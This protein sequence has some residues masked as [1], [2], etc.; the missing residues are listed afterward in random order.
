MTTIEQRVIDALQPGGSDLTIQHGGPDNLDWTWRASCNDGATGTYREGVGQ[1][2]Q[3]ALDA[4][5]AKLAESDGPKCCMC[6]RYRTVQDAYDYNPLQVV[7]G[8]PLG[9]YSGDDGEICPQC[10]T[11]TIRG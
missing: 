2:M 8:Q 9:W 5:A 10:M 4:L 1:T 3:E 7:T 6:G 11:T